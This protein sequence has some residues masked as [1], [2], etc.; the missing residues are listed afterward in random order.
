MINCNIVHS[1]QNI[2]TKNVFGFEW[3]T[4]RC[5]VHVVFLHYKTLTYEFCR[6]K[7]F[8]YYYA[9]SDIIENRC[10]IHLDAFV[11]PFIENRQRATFICINIKSPASFPEVL[12]PAR[13]QSRRAVVVVTSFLQFPATCID[14]AGPLFR[15]PSRNRRESC[16]TGLYTRFICARSLR[17]RNGLC[18]NQGLT[19]VHIPLYNGK[20]SDGLL[21][22]TWEN[23]I[24]YLPRNLL[25][26][27]CINMYETPAGRTDYRETSKVIISRRLFSH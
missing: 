17:A 25:L 3:V 19:R 14:T 7:V 5:M 10:A 22:V 8:H 9:A 13:K 21:H 24:Y 11:D 23:R 18:Q 26:K 20:T 4:E 6:N 12:F 15:F 2:A 27:A 1:T 16:V